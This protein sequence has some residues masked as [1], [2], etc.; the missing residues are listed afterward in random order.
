MQ[1][2]LISAFEFCFKLL[3]YSISFT[4]VKQGFYNQSTLE[5]NEA[6]ITSFRESYFLS[7]KIVMHILIGNI[8]PRYPWPRSH[9]HPQ[10]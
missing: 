8:S 10:E 2:E 1:P 4:I 9:P 6:Q 7:Q 3:F 5:K